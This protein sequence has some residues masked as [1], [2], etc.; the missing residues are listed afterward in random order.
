MQGK[1]CTAIRLPHALNGVIGI[2]IFIRHNA[3]NKKMDARPLK[4]IK[5]DKQCFCSNAPR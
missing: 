5:Y 1:L 4:Y 2:S 3:T